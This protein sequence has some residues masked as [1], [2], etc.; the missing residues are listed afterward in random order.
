MVSKSSFHTAGCWSPSRAGVCFIGKSNGTI[1]IWDFMDQSHKWTMQYSVGSI[2]ISSMTFHES[3]QN[4]MAVGLQEGTLHILELPFT[5][6]RKVGDEDR[7]MNEYWGREIDSVK[8][9][10]RRFEKR[11]EESQA[12]RAKMDQEE[13]N[14]IQREEKK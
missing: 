14:R 1:D 6:V 5:L 2:G 13:R 8:Y 11:F 12:L 4:I 10:N 3:S 7:T 9:F